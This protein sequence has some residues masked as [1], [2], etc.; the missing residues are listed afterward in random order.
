MAQSQACPDNI[1]FN[2]NALTHW[3][4]Y[5]GNNHSGN[6]PTAIKQRYDKAV[7]TP[8][9]T[10]GA[11]VIYEYNLAVPGIQVIAQNGIDPFGGFPTIPNINGY[12]YTNSVKLGST[13]VSQNSTSNGG[14]PGGYIRGISYDITVPTSATSEPYTM[15]Y[16]YA[17]VLENG[18]HNTIEQPLFSATLTTNDSVI[19]CASPKYNLPTNNNAQEGGRGATLDSAAAKAEGFTVSSKLSPTTSQVGTSGTQ[20]HLQDVWTKGWTEVTFDLSPFRG[21]TVKLTFEADN[22]I[23]GGHFAYAYIALR[24][25][26]GGLSISGEPIACTNTNLTYSI[27]ALTGATYEWIIPSGWTISSATDTSVVHVNIGDQPGYIIAHEI[28][29]CADLRDTLFVKTNPPTIPGTLD[30]DTIVC[31]NSNTNS[32]VLSGNRG[33][34]LKWIQSTDGTTWS[35]IS[36]TTNRYNAVNLGA[37]TTFRALVRNGPTCRTDTSTSATVTVNPKSVG[38]NLDPAN[39]N[40]CKGQDPGAVLTLNGNTGAVQLW[41]SSTDSVNWTTYFAAGADS[42]YRVAGLTATTHYRVVVKSGVCP[43]DT[44]SPANIKLFDGLFPEASLNPADTTIC[45][46]GKARLDASVTIGTSFIWNT[47]DNLAGPTSGNINSPS[48]VSAVATPPLT[49]DYIL[50]VT[51]ANCP[52]PLLDTF[53]VVVLAAIIVNPGN[54]TSV[55]VNQP[56]QFHATSSDS[57]DSF[58]WYPALGLNDPGIS[59]PTA[60]Y[61]AG[62]DSVR[63]VVTATSSYG[64]QGSADV[65]V[66]IYKTGPDIFVPNAFTPDKATNSVFRPIPVGIS[67]L[68]YFRIY[69]RWGQLVFST[70]RAGQGWNGTLDGKPQG[71]SSYVWMVQGIDYQGNTI[72]KKG[73]MTLI[74]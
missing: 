22:C 54:D 41:Q 10:L 63:Y 29:G 7:S 34:V 4:A 12:Q 55:V 60:T 30:G 15:T 43:A 36:D 27:P 45:Y 69:N 14:A 57:G 44:S 64:C 39:K 1:N 70:N 66:K 71:L 42:A 52:N 62:F 9:G 11:T 56:L 5:T 38:G 67:T 59:N 35:D 37:T 23:P 2:L 65:L 72:T 13:S 6:G 47:L 51:N 74:R 40:I 28:N 50:T 19:S 32:I 8:G 18:T 49:A 33:S 24:N 21:R 53:H 31:T 48:T 26:C 20:V 16:A 46:G 17:M 73:T 61:D 25:S 3:D 68:N 58:L